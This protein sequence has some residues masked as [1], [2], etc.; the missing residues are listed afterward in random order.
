MKRP[1]ANDFFAQF[2]DE[3]PLPDI[4]EGEAIELR[5]MA[6]FDHDKFVD[7]LANTF[8]RIAI[9]AVAVLYLDVVNSPKSKTHT[10]LMIKMICRI[11][12]V[13]HMLEMTKNGET[14][15][16]PGLDYDE[17]RVELITRVQAFKRAMGE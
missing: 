10:N 2:G 11:L 4:T 1:T 5:K 15:D 9:D 16:P 6:T 17:I 7:A 12:A 8:D 13:K 14:F 3:S